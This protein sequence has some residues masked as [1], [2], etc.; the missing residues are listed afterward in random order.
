MCCCNV[1][2]F[3]S[4][5]MMRCILREQ[6]GS[7]VEQL[8]DVSAV[9]FVRRLSLRDELVGLRSVAELRLRRDGG[10]LGLPGHSAR[11]CRQDARA[12]EP[13][14]VQE[15]RGRRALHLQGK[16]PLA[17]MSRD[18]TILLSFKFTCGV[19]VMDSHTGQG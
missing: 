19:A 4:F 11:R 18:G 6:Q 13:S 1:S 2:S 9:N 16:A 7:G 15:H 8:C 5:A 3:F 14:P 17:A 12:S 10:S